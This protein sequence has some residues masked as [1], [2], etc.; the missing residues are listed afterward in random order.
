[1]AAVREHPIRI[2]DP[3]VGDCAT[4]GV[5]CSAPAIS[6]SER[7]HPAVRGA[8][9]E[10]A[11]ARCWRCRSSI[12]T[13]PWACCWCA[14]SLPAGSR[15]TRSSCCRAF[16]SQSSIAIN[17]ARLFHEIEDKSRQLEIASQHKSQFVANMSHELRTPLAAMLGYA[18]L[19]QENIYGALPAKATPIVERIRSNGRHLLGLIN[20]VLDIS[21]IESGQFKLNLSEYA[22][23]SMVETVRVAT[24]FARRGQE[25]CVSRRCRQGL[26]AWPRRRAAADAGAAQSRR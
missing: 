8:A 10:R 2:G 7:D 25:A 24:E 23:S 14:G 19:L 4:K 1:M 18:E 22:L 9:Q 17:N 21:K 15:P 16:A 3:V 12:R 5:A 6:S 13:R 20:T 26:A 11:C